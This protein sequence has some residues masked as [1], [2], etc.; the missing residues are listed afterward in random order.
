MAT[1]GNLK[2]AQKLYVAYY[3][4]PAD[5]SGLL[6]WAEKIEEK[7]AAAVINDFGNSAE[8]VARFG[9]LSNEAL[10]SGIYEQA[11]NRAPDRE[12]LDFYT[13]K[14]DS[15]ELTLAN[16]ALTIV[17]NATNVDK[18][19]AD[20]LI[21]KV[22]AADL[23]TE[24]A[25]NRQMGT[26][27]DNYAASFLAGIDAT[28]APETL[29]MASIIAAIPQSDMPQPEMPS[30][31][32]EPPLTLGNPVFNINT[33]STDSGN[34]NSLTITENEIAD[35]I[36]AKDALLSS[37]S[38]NIGDVI[39]LTTG[40]DEFV[41]G[42]IELIGNSQLRD[43]ASQVGRDGFIDFAFFNGELVT[44]E[45]V[46]VSN[47]AFFFGGG[48]LEEYFGY[49]WPDTDG[50]QTITRDDGQRFELDITLYDAI[51]VSNPET[52]FDLG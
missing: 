14:L 50:A 18:P 29:D 19:D 1:S 25:G 45:M 32:G 3:G 8:F 37:S 2:L 7:G 17:N 30:G 36:S 31:D 27:A 22:A 48:S 13:E 28:S 49:D 4:R 15:G 33:S 24:N 51:G 44:P 38:S 43:L 26:D 10:V 46:G 47:E 12:G 6:F 5:A 42:N 11:F 41:A 16:I 20:V 21:N 34:F 35:F 40:D 52:L 23:Y 39:T 9:N